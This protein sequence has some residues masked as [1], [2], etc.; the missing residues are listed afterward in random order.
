[1]K[2]WLKAGILED[3]ILQESNGML[4]MEE[5]TSWSQKILDELT[6]QI[7]FTLRNSKKKEDFIYTTAETIQQD[8]PDNLTPL[9]LPSPA[10]PSNEI[11]QNNVLNSATQNQAETNPAPKP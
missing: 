5:N 2:K 3:G 11:P 10:I 4:R 1:M 9:S 8:E 6:K 7:S